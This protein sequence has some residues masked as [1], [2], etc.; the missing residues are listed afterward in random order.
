MAVGYNDVGT[1]TSGL[2][3]IY[4]N[5]VNG[6]EFL[7]YN[8]SAPTFVASLPWSGFIHTSPVSGAVAINRTGNFSLGTWS[9][10]TTMGVGFSIP[11][12]GTSGL[13]GPTSISIMVYRATIPPPPNMLQPS[14]I[15]TTTLRTQFV[16]PSDGG[17]AITSYAIQR[18]T[19]A[20]FTQNLVGIPGSFNGVNDW[21]GLTPGTTYYFRAR[22]QNAVG[23]S[24]WS[25]TVSATTLPSVP[26]GMTVTP[27]P[28]GLS[29]TVTLTPPGGVSGVDSYIVERRLVGTTT[30]TSATT[31]T[32]S[33]TVTG[34][35]PGATYEWR[36]SAMIGTYQSPWTNWTPIIQPNPSTSPGDYFDGSTPATPDQTYRW[37][38]TVNLS[39]SQAVGHAP[40]GWIAFADG[41]TTSGGTGVVAR[42]SDPQFGQF[43]ARATFFSDATAAGFRAGTAHTDPGRTDVTGN[44]GY[45]GSIYVKASRAQSL[46]A[47]ITWVTSAGAYI[48]ASAGPPVAVAANAWT[49]LIVSAN[50]PVN[51]EWAAIRV[52]DLAGPSWSLWRAGDSLVMDG[53][54]ISLGLVPI[55]YFDGS[56]PDANNFRYDWTGP[57]N[58]STSIRTSVATNPSDALLDPDCPPVPA[59]PRPPVILDECIVETGVWRRY[60]AI[61]PAAEVSDW[62]DV[63]PTFN[64]TTFGLAERQVRIRIYPNPFNY[65]ISQVDTSNWCSEQIISYVPP[66]TYM[67]LDG[68][69]Q[70]VFADVAG[71]PTQAADHLLYGTGG[72]PASWPILSCGISYLVSFDTPLDAP[73]GNLRVAVD[74]TRRAY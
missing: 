62:L 32:T 2:L 21:T 8:G 56:F 53:A 18:A 68:E 31:N 3:R 39:T 14:L 15:T 63:L 19:D 36:A 33:L 60:F 51:A 28:S 13:G 29:A 41:A 54:M 57:A 24:G 35:T 4:D 74:L 5:G 38:G 26:P 1:G 12:T 48:T 55:D 7:I 45:S 42:V 59:P 37:T 20:A 73:E 23:V 58:A 16:Q 50:S 30:A 70:R 64:L 44:T 67:V 61:I 17:S 71:G 9:V 47:E 65:P 34:L 43:S 11:A 66:S 10:T 22:A 27:T 72:T 69:L 40:T 25:N 6:V 52:V 49:R 46:A